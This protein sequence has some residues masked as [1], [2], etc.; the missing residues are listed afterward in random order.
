VSR[1][2]VGNA[3]DEYLVIDSDICLKSGRRT[4]DRVTLRGGTTPSWVNVLL[5]FSVIGWVFASGMSTRRYR[6]QVPFSHAIH[7]RW[8]RW[9]RVAW[10]VGVGG[11]GATIWAAAAGVQVEWMLLCVGVAALGMGLGN[12][13]MNNVGVR[14]NRDN[15]LVLTRVHP[16][17]AAAIKRA[18]SVRG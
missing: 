1:V 9:S 10:V 12:A 8:R 16:T 7:A 5:L 18:T 15:E 6:M 14:E 2:V 4:S 13:S 17:A 11:L 3:G